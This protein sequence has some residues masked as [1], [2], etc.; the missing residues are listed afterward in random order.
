MITQSFLYNAIFFSCTLVL[1]KIYG[2]DENSARGICWELESLEDV[3]SPLG[4]VHRIPAFG[5]GGPK[6]QA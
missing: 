6:P 4:L 3:A 5:A 2:V 1:T